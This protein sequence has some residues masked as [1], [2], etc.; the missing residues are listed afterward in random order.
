MAQRTILAILL[1]LKSFFKHV[2]LYHI[3]ELD[4]Q[5]H[6]ADRSFVRFSLSLTATYYRVACYNFFFFLS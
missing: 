2:I 4:T 1:L 3:F 5:E 6:F